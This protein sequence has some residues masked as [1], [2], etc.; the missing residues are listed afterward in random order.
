M[1]A[2]RE[3]QPP[4][5]PREDNDDRRI[6][7]RRTIEGNNLESVHRH[8]LSIVL[9]TVHHS[10]GITRAS[11]TH[12]SGLN[13]STI[14]ALVGELAEMGLVEEVKPDRH[15]RPGRPSSVVR[16]T[17]ET[18]AIAVNPEV[19]AVTVGVVGLNGIVYERI[20]YDVEARPSAHEAAKISGAIIQGL[21]T[22]LGS[23][24][25]IAGIG[26]AVPGLVRAIDG[27]V[28]YAPHLG[29]TD[30][31]VA[32]MLK[33]ATG[34]PATAGND[35]NLGAEAERLFGAGQCVNDMIYLNGGASGIGAGI[36][37]DG[38]LLRGAHGFAGEIG[39][40]RVRTTAHDGDADIG[41]LESE[42]TQVALMHLLG[43]ENADLDALEQAL[44]VAPSTTTRREVE[45]QLEVLG[46]VLA[47]AVNV[48]NPELVIL[49]GFLGT[50][51]SGAPGYLER[52]VKK[53][54]LA[55]STGNL[56]IT[57]A[58]LGSDLLMVGAAELAFA[59]VLDDPAGWVASLDS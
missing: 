14:A 7:R 52:I 9:R 16:P 58:K 45:R 17:S 51:Y 48:L 25:R 37:S 36:V 42:V 23:R 53:E 29:W 8:N 6:A 30:E 2:A 22:G 5:A 18:V 44:T 4:P 32:R 59:S 55:A 31:P 35:A 50:L 49:G 34:L 21:R 43:L 26:V 27:V 54:A 38:H 39:H 15:S 56:R 47:G 13:R 11:L 3:V 41:T 1:P 20:R 24:A 33:A 28:R 40:T 12:E 46:R 10:G 57:K 19:D